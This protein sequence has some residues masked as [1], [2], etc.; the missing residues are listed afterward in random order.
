MNEPTC[1]AI[2]RA[3]DEPLA[4]T[5]PKDGLVYLLV[6]F[7][8]EWPSEGLFASALPDVVKDAVEHWAGAVP[9][10]RVLLAR[11]GLARRSLPSVHLFRTVPGKRLALRFDLERIEDAASLDVLGVLA[12]TA[13]DPRAVVLDAPHYLVCTHGKRDACCALHGGRVATALFAQAG[14]RVL[15]V[16]HLGGHRFAAV[17]VTAPDGLC[18]G[19]VD[20]EEAPAFVRAHDAGQIYDLG[21]LRGRSG[22]SDPEQ[23]AEITQRVARGLTGV[24]DVLPIGSGPTER[25]VRVTVSSLGEHVSLEV[26]KQVLDYERPGSCG[27]KPT[28]AVTLLATLAD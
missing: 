3:H 11:H 28:R 14:E 5:G 4:G 20:V 8:G 12:G 27:E 7:D 21:R 16:S 18:F 26:T 23:I 2:S 13:T 22:F 6:S 1:S 25:G 15:R 17:V 19:R 24:D 9:G 10:M